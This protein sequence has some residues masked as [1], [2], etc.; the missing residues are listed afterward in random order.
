MSPILPV[1]GV[2]Y[3]PGCSPLA[4]LLLRRRVDILGIAIASDQLLMTVRALL[5]VA[6]RHME[7][8]L[9]HST[10]GAGAGVGAPVRAL[11]AKGNP[12]EAPLADLKLRDT[13]RSG[14]TLWPARDHALAAI[15]HE[16]PF[17]HLARSW[18]KDAT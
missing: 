3:L 18:A 13:L 4:P 1:Y 7:L 6:S 11:A 10:I 9:L 14:D 15:D 2:T 12:V 17:S 16:L 8:A 5:Y